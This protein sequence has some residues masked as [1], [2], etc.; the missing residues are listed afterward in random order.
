MRSNTTTF[1]R[2][3]CEVCCTNELTSVARVNDD[4]YALALPSEWRILW[5]KSERK[6]QFWCGPCWA[7]FALTLDLDDSVA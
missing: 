5:S 3:R 4:E 7:T 2:L 1:K 6:L